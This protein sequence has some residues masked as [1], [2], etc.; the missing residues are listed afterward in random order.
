MLLKDS[1]EP[2]C[3]NSSTDRAKTEP[4]RANPMTDI[5]DP[6][7]AYVLKESAEPIC[8]KSSTDN[9]EPTREKLRKDR[10]EPI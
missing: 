5:A 9:A 2:R 8:K 10:D 6:I 1:E 4:R 7:L 3:V